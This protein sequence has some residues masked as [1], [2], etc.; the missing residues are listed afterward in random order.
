MNYTEAARKTVVTRV[1]IDHCKEDDP[2]FPHWAVP[3]GKVVDELWWGWIT[4]RAGLLPEQI[5]MMVFW[6]E[7]EAARFLEKFPVGAEIGELAWAGM[8]AKR[9]ERLRKMI[10]EGFA[11]GVANAGDE[12][13]SLA[14]D[15]LE[16]AGV[17]G[18][19]YGAA[20][21]VLDFLG[22]QRVGALKSRYRDNWSVAAEFEYCSMKFP[23]SSPAYL[24]TSMAACMAS[25]LAIA[26]MSSG[27][28]ATIRF[29]PDGL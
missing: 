13:S 3:E 23:H 20:Q 16:K 29:T 6:S 28:T 7:E 21:H 2:L 19:G 14:F 5:K 10:D 1:R 26:S 24:R 8:E 22:K 25:S 9:H 4:T 12:E 27:S 15:V 18:A 17:L 11:P